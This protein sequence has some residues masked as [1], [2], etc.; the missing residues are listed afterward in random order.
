[1]KVLKIA[2]IVDIFPSISETFI[3]NQITYL[4]DEGHDVTIFSRVRGKQVVVHDQ[5]NKYRLI[6]RTIY[7]P[8]KEK[9]FLR[10]F[11]TI[12]ASLLK[13]KSMRFAK[14]I[15]KCLNIFKLG[16]PSLSLYLAYNYSVLRSI[17]NYDVIHAHFGTSAIFVSYLKKAGLLRDTNIVTSFH[18]SDLSPDVKEHNKVLYRDVFLYSKLLTVNTEYSFNLLTEITGH[19]F[20][21]DILPV[22]L[23][24]DRF[25]KNRNLILSDVGINITFCGRLIPLKGAHICLEIIRR[26]IEEVDL[27]IKFQIIGNGPEY[28]SLKQLI[29][30][31]ELE[32]VVSLLGSLNQNE[33]LRTLSSTDIFLFPGTYDPA[34]GRCETQGLVIQEAQAMEIPVVISD[35]GGMKYGI[36]DGGTGFVV[37]D[38]NIDAYVDILLNLS[39][40]PELREKMGKAGRE[41]VISCYD[42]RY[43]GKKL[44]ELY[45]SIL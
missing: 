19:S 17:E 11:T 44:L 18:G 20:R 22:G 23:D 42:Y 40:N 12:F 28:E 6:N 10:R 5:V 21:I 4:I 35:V 25:Q 33:V 32:D 29:S 38:G 43:L 1:M 30:D 24:T 15:L 2:F 8:P 16:R 27:D 31:L 45:M 3:L 37:K 34:T 26:L 39:L 41:H 7:F 36:V 9:S 14:N 13:I